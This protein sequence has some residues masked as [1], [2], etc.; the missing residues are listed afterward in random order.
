MRLT[1]RNRLLAAAVLSAGLTGLAQAAPPAEK[2]QGDVRYV[3]GGIGLDESTEMKSMESQ[4]SLALT[5]AEQ[6]NGKA[7][8]LANIPVT[9]TDAQGRDGV[10]GQYRRPISA[11][12]TAAQA[13]MR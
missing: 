12:A 11:G 1:N 7:D 8:Y 9:I 13:A 2:T 3:S 10:V 5:F 4:Y 6:D